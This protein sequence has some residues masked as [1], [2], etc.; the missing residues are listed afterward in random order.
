MKTCESSSVRLHIPRSI[1]STTTT[2]ILGVNVKCLTKWSLPPFSS[3]WLSRRQSRKRSSGTGG[4]WLN[5]GC[6]SQL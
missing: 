3:I 1:T 4:D 5:V 2:D 6:L